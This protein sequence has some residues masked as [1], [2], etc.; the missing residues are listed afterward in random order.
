MPNKMDELPLDRAI[1]LYFAK[2]VALRA[3]DMKKLIALRQEHPEIFDK[4]KDKEIRDI[5]LYAKKFE[6]SPQYRIMRRLI[7]KESLQVITDKI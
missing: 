2:H 5:I 7:L 3:G 1:E 4:N 6:E